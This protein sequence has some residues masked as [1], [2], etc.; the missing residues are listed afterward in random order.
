MA[1][2]PADRDLARAI[3]RSPVLDR[4]LR[5]YWLRVLPYLGEDEKA[6]LWATLQRADR[7]LTGDT[8]SPA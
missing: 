8:E 3:R 6:R 2:E 1:R 4:Q 7:E 5:A